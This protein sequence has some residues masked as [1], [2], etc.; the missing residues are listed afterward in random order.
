MSRR[1]ITI[2]VYLSMATFVCHAQ[3]S[4]V[5]AG[6]FN[7]SRSMLSIR[8]RPSLDY[9]SQNILSNLVVTIRWLSSCKVSLG[10]VSS[11]IYGVTKQGSED[12]S[13]SYT[14]QKF[15][16]ANNT[17]LNWIARSDYELFTVAVNQ[18]GSGTGTFELTN[19][20]PGGEWY[21]E[22]SAVDH[23]NSTDPFYQASVRN[24][25]LG[26]PEK[27]ASPKSSRARTVK[28]GR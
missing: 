3:T 18:T 4:Q 2:L 5:Q 26:S 21:V 27:P 12:T 15:G 6:I 16:A 8:A 17:P 9:R 14:Y 20:L 13:G 10:P 25:P 7:P 11:P 24:V 28:R 22:L 19:S 1:A 23:T